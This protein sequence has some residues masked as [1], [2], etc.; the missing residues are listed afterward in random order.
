MNEVKV[1]KIE[2]L[3]LD[4]SVDIGKE[5]HPIESEDERKLHD[6]LIAKYKEKYHK[7]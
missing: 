1:N 7:K 3:I 5:P 4:D 6:E 2:Y